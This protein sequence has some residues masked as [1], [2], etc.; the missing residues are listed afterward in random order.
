MAPL[1]SNGKGQVWFKI[2]E[3]GYNPDTKDWCIDVFNRQNGKLD[4]EIPADIKQGGYLVRTEVIALHEAERQY[5]DDKDAGAQYYPNCAQVYII[6]NGT[7]EPKGVAIP[8]VYEK[9]QPGIHFN[10][11]NG[12]KSYPIPG[13]ELY[14]AGSIALSSEIEESSKAD[15]LI[16]VDEPPEPSSYLENMNC[17]QKR[18]LRK[19][20]NRR[21][22]NVRY[23]L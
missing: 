5:G 12:Y 20:R 2:F 10:L 22:S 1:E 21:Q 14:T 16:R 6:G 8:G 13:P 15:S 23:D 3:L 19:R 9:S 4:I 11:W 18:K 7:A 17:I